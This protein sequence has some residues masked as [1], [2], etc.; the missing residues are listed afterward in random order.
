MSK[1]AE[2]MG[3]AVPKGERTALAGAEPA[4]VRMPRVSGRRFNRVVARIAAPGQAEMR[5]RR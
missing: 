2:F 3:L 5:I 1:D 4:G